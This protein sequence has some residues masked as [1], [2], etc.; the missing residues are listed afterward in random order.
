MEEMHINKDGYDYVVKI[1]NGE[2]LSVYKLHNGHKSI[3]T[4]SELSDIINELNAMVNDERIDIESLK[5]IIIEMI[6]SKEIN[7][8]EDLLKYFKENN[9]SQEMQD[10]LKDELNDFL[11]QELKL[12]DKNIYINYL[13]TLEPYL[14]Q[15]RDKNQLLYSTFE[16][17]HGILKHKLVEHDASTNKIKV[18]EEKLF[19]YCQAAKDFLIMPF[20]TETVQSGELITSQRKTDASLLFDD[21]TYNLHTKNNVIVSVNGISKEFGDRLDKKARETVTLN[22][23]ETKE[24]D[25]KTN[26]VEEYT[27]YNQ[28]LDDN[29]KEYASF[30]SDEELNALKKEKGMTRTLAKKNPYTP[31]NKGSIT[32]LVLMALIAIS[33]GIVVSL[34]IYILN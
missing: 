28:S 14:L 3:I 11:T 30:L 21:T 29:L 15:P 2:V 7:N 31:Y 27:P 33:I 1:E 5:D 10:Q 6:K 34:T 17:S 20:I 32:S 26:A 8:I 22:H 4:K 25:S 16:V 19:D 18:V 13:K 12:D 9:I 23:N 24:V